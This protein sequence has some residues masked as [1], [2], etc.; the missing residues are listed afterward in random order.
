MTLSF[1]NKTCIVTGGASGIGR[2]ATLALANLGAS[3]VVA[4]LDEN[5]ANETRALASDAADRVYFHKTNVAVSGEVKDLVESTVRRFGRLDGAFNNAGIM[6]L[7]SARIV[8]G[9]E[10]NWDKVLGINLKGTWLCMKHQIRAMR[11]SGG[12]SIVNA[13]S[14]AGMS[15]GFASA[16]YIASKHGVLGL[17]KVGALECA[18]QN[19]RVNAICP[20]Y[21]RTPM[22]ERLTRI[23]PGLEQVLVDKEPMG[24]LGSPEEVANAVIWLLSDAASFVTGHA[25]VVDGGIL[26]D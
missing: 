22:L 24:R 15:G 4:D 6:G 11:K 12:G 25:L 13:A 9:T 18:K 19:I 8:E 23:G 20:G 21:I 5:T 10:E 16:A 1:D 3:V 7:A 17:T 14:A 2:A 26:A